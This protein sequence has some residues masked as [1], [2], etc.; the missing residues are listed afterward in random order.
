MAGMSL[1]DY[2]IAELRRSTER[3]TVDELRE[4]LSRL[5]PLA[6]REAPARVVRTERDRR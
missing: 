2:L 5:E 4:R 1:S 3:L 6:V